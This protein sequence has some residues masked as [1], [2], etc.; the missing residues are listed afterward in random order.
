MQ[1]ELNRA[2]SIQASVSEA[3]GRLNISKLEL[4]LAGLKEA[5][6]GADFWQDSQSAQ[7]VMQKIATLEG[8]IE[9]WHAL[10]AG[11]D[12][13]VGL[14]EI[15]DQTMLPE[16]VGQVADLEQAVLTL[17]TGHRCCIACMSAGPNLLQKNQPRFPE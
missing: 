6:E 7:G 16:L 11:L 10:Q 1:D 2:R 13:A 15:G 14:L 8:R 9:P 3:V 12:D 5:S 4:E 17:K